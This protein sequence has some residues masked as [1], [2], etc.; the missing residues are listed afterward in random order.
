MIEEG[1]PLE[2]IAAKYRT[3]VS[4]IKVYKA[5]L[6]GTL[7]RMT[8]RK[9]YERNIGNAVTQ[10]ELEQQ[11]RAQDRLERRRLK[12]EVLELYDKGLKP[13]HIVAKLG[14]EHDFVRNALSHTRWGQT[15]KKG[16]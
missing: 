10:K 1:C 2:S 9:S 4:T 3:G 7:S 5:A 16:E 13:R 11:K 12:A 8:N 15:L 14:V 6:E